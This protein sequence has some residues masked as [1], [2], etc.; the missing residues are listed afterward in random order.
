MMNGCPACSRAD[1]PQVLELRFRPEEA[2]RPPAARSGRG[3]ARYLD[4]LPVQADSFS[5]LGEGGTPLIRSRKIGPELGLEQLWFKNDSCNPTWSFKDRYVSVSVGIARQFGF[6]AVAVTSTGNLGVSTAAYCARAG[7]SCH[8]I[9]PRDFPAIARR[10][11]EAFGAAIITVEA[12]QRQGVFETLCEQHGWFPLG[13]FLPRSVSNPFGVEG[14]KTFAYELIEALGEAPAAVLFPSARGNGLYGAW[15]GFREALDWGWIE[16]MPRMIACQPAGADSLA[17]AMRR[18]SDA[19]ISLPPFTSV[20]F[21]A[22]EPVAGPHALSAI[23]ASG[24]TAFSVGEDDI[25]SAQARLAREEGIFI[26][27]SS[28]LSVAALN[29]AVAAGIVDRGAPVV[30]ILTGPGLA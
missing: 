26:E 22:S 9:A 12:E 10:R 8:I 2:P 23:R 5:S 1:A 3:L 28:A 11:A 24:G 15:K 27:T 16:R 21:S 13:L 29:Q 7:L 18:G 25:L 30:S 4:L 17:E 14:Y 6:S 20:A 19:P